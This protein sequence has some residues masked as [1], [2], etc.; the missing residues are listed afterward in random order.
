MTT[1]LQR[2]RLK[3]LAQIDGLIDDEFVAGA[4]SRAYPKQP[5]PANFPNHARS[6][7][8][9]SLA[10]ALVPSRGEIGRALNQLHNRLMAAIR[11]D[12]R[13][14]A[15]TALEQM[16]ESVLVYLQ[17]RFPGQIPLPDDIRGSLRGIDLAKASLGFC[18]AGAEIV[19][20]RLRPSGRQSRPTLRVLPRYKQRP[21]HPRD[22][23][24]QV[25]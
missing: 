21:G 9:A 5:L 17:H 8:R 3:P 15:A 18:V 12:D 11:L 14:R 6:C 25:R 7:V 19:P 20:G 4:W 13:E 1:R 2:E 10:F 16:P 24:L 23:R 22:D